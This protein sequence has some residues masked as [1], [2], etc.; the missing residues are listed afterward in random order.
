[1][2]LKSRKI[3]TKQRGT[4]VCGRGKKGSRRRDSGR[5]LAGSKKH[6]YSWILKNDP[7]HFGRR[8]MKSLQKKL[9]VVN[10]GY[11]NNLAVMKDVKELDVTELGFE[12]VIGGGKVDQALKV[13]AKSVTEAA[14]Q[15]I[16]TAGGSVTLA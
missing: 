6:M 14:K 7:D 13:T 8:K 1:M 10:V 3:R 2:A 9:K 15:K 12:K 5:G 16:E 11:L 4:R